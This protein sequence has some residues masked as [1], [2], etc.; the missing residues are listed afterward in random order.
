MKK[1]LFIVFVLFLGLVT[2]AEAKVKRYDVKSAK[3]FYKINGSGKVLGMFKTS[4]VGEEKLVFKEWGNIELRDKKEKHSGMKN[5]DIHNLIKL[6][7]GMTYSVNFKEKTIYKAKD[8]LM[9][10]NEDENKDLQKQGKEMLESLGGK[11][12]GYGKF[13]GYKCEVWEATG[14]KMW[15]YKGVPLKSVSNILGLN[16]TI[17]ATKA[18]FNTYISKKDLALPNFPIVRVEDVQEKLIEQENQNN[19]VSQEKKEQQ[20]S[21]NNVQKAPEPEEDISKDLNKLI[22]GVGQ[23]FGN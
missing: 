18:K 17:E 9:S 12:T 8:F 7:N 15:L 6:D 13:L 11:K 4:I 3:V 19:R 16:L 10:S 21:H 23:L 5:E 22:K 14:M 20:P 1:R 2:F